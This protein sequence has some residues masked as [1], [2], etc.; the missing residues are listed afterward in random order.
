MVDFPGHPVWPYLYAFMASIKHV[1]RPVDTPGL[2]LDNG[3][4]SCLIDL[5]NRHFFTLVTVYLNPVE[6]ELT[7]KDNS[8]YTGRLKKVF[9]NLFLQPL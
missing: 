8:T 7:S 1:R 2:S 9:L 6:L 5:V 4:E 3:I